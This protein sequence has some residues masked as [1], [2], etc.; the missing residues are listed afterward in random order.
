MGKEDSKSTVEGLL[1]V[2]RV[3][4]YPRSWEEQGVFVEDFTPGRRERIIKVP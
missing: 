4:V 1:G 2:W 3:V